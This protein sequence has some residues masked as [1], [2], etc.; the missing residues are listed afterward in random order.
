MRT[1]SLRERN[2]LNTQSEIVETAIKLFIEKGFDN[3]PVEMICDE[4]GISRGTF[5]NYFPQKELIFA[6]I[7]RQRLE[8]VNDLIARHIEAHK[9]SSFDDIIDL[10][11]S[12]ARENER[13]PD[14]FKY[15]VTQIFQRP[16]VRETLQKLR[17]ELTRIL[18]E[19]MQRIKRAGG[20]P[21]TRHS[22]KA[23]AELLISIFI[24][25]NMQW[26]TQ[27]ETEAGWLADT[28]RQRLRIAGEGIVGRTSEN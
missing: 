18:V 25:T 11:V 27:E 6:E 15:I 13:Q 10:L 14:Y 20:M 26:I 19:N 5:F 21:V 9:M 23:I 12:I 2:R 4:V 17:G 16:I 28:M 1:M 3:V 7:A 24:G 8:F 22:N